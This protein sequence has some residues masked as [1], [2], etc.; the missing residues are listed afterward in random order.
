MAVVYGA[1]Y[2]AVLH[3]VQA[4]VK[5]TNLVYVNGENMYAS[6]CL[7]LCVFCF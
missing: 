7:C 3:I 4:Q 6:V 5:N 1:L 2:N